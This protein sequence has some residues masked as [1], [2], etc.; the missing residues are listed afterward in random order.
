MLP[1][2]YAAVTNAEATTRFVCPTQF[3]IAHWNISISVGIM[4]LTRCVPMM[5]ATG[6]L[7]GAKDIKAPP[8]MPGTQNVAIQAQRLEL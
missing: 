1:I 3:D 5:I 2:E 6:L 4:A 8:I 7:R